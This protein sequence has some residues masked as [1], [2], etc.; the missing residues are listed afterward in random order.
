[1]QTVAFWELPELRETGRW[2]LEVN[3]DALAFASPGVLVTGVRDGRVLLHDI[4]SREVQA[5][6]IGHGMPVTA[7]AP[8]GPGRLVSAA[9]DGTLWL[10]DLAAG[11]PVRHFVGSDGPIY[12]LALADA[13]G[14]LVSVGRDGTLREWE[15]ASGA[16]RR[17]LPA[18]DGPAW[19]LGV[20]P[21][22]RFVVTAGS[23]A[24]LRVWHRETGDRI[25]APV[26]AS[27]RAEPWLDS[28]EPGPRM[29]RKCAACHALGPDEPA[30]SG[31]HLAGLF[32]RRAGSVDG[33]RYSSALRRADLVWDGETLRELFARGPDVYLPGTKMPVQKIRD[34][35]RLDALI[36]YLRGLTANAH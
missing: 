34:P 31:P 14:T 3:F 30:R 13:G 21:D 33:Y 36:A 10:W 16:L 28:D 29:F 23:D 22:G 18:H 1:D 4:A 19:S 9:L 27:G 15:L 25:G 8:A 17:A 6:L 26:A 7:L 32:G 5:E 11:K 12:R 35:E 20:T 2:D 24:S